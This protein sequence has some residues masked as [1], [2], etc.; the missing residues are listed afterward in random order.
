MPSEIISE[1]LKLVFK[2]YQEDL[3]TY[4]ETRDTI[5][6]DFIL[7]RIFD[8]YKDTLGFSP[9]RIKAHA[10]TVSNPQDN[11]GEDRHIYY[12][13]ELLE[14]SHSLPQWL[15]PNLI[16]SG[17]GLYLCA[18]KPK[19]GKTLIFG[20]QLLYSIAVSGE[21]LGLPCQR[22][23]V[24]FFQCEEPL[25][26]VVKRI[27]TKGFY[28]NFEGIQEAIDDKRIRIERDFRIDSDLIYLKETAEEYQP[29]LIIYD[30]LS[31]ITAHLDASE[32]DAAFA[33]Y[34]YVLQAMHNSIGIPGLLI[35]HNNKK[36]EGGLN[37]VAGSSRI[38]AATD[39][40]IILDLAPGSNHQVKLSTVPREG[41]PVNLIIERT[42]DKNSFWSYQTVEVLNVDPNVLNWE[43]RIIRELVLNVEKK[44]TASE[45]AQSLR[46]EPVG[47]FMTALERLADSYQIGE[48]FTKDGVR[49]YWLSENSPWLNI[50]ST[51]MAVEI[52]EAQKLLSCTTKEEVLNLT[53][54][55][56]AKGE[57]YKEKI[58]SLLHEDEKNKVYNLVAP[59]KFNKEEWVR[60]LDSQEAFKII[61]ANYFSDE[62]MWVYSVEG[63]EKTFFEN[64]LEVHPDYTAYDVTF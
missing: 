23:K 53:S 19:V 38:P 16:G 59:R 44:Y 45:L 1:D 62:K 11:S 6:R 18:A 54:Q 63:S 46:T 30:S 43:K 47:Q 35:H 64:E 10:A 57:D 4:V 51:P 61:E 21:F 49:V 40:V 39:G 15:V 22:G 37:K 29:S 12:L 24:L 25:P 42:R 60:V 55:W 50:K 28:E 3:K 34:V 17:G 27:R 36:D 14:L 58:W 20:Y 7:N 33:S 9:N 31:R 13:G 5:I 48:T 2:Q 56:L 41:T 8:K 52:E 32:N 26:T